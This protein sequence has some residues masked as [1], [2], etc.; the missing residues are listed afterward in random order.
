MAPELRL[1]FR[2][3]EEMNSVKRSVLG[4]GLLLLSQAGS[5]GHAAGRKA[6]PRASV[7]SDAKDRL[8]RAAMV[9]RRRLTTSQKRAV[10]QA[11]LVGA[12]E[13]GSDGRPARVGTY[14]FKQIRA[15]QKILA[16]AGFSRTERKLLMK[17]KVV[18]FLENMQKLNDTL[19][20]V[21]HMMGD[22]EVAFQTKALNE[23]S[24]G[25]YDKAAEYQMQADQWKLM[26]KMAE[27]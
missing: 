11:H 8:S 26:K 4:I 19:A 12:N 1:S 27:R 5:V 18:G 14:T 9:V 22:H 17:R 13:A 2:G 23:I 24:K 25:N 20:N 21:N 16:G 7:E 3:R 15:K 6:T 10:I